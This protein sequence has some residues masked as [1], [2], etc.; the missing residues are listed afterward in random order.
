MQDGENLSW[1][2]PEY[3]ERE[4]SADWF[5]ALGVI[6]ATGA[7]TAI[8]YS[9][10]FF[11]ILLL[12]GGGLLWFYGKK[13]PDWVEYELTG[14]GLRIKSRLYPY[15]Y[16]KSFWVQKEPNKPLLFI[17]TERFFMPIISIPIEHDIA[18]QIHDIFL[19]KGIPEEE[20]R[21]HPSEK[22]MDALGF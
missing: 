15:Q 4:R 12:L 11:A 1:S 13:S 18:A 7:A 14:K 21:E 9:N 5:W 2:A 6:V 3:E 8:I 10:Y 16:I 19:A 17:K 20:M 22:I